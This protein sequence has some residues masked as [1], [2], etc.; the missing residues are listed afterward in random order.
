MR[1]LIGLLL[2]LNLGVFLAGMAMQY[3]SPAARAPLVF[4]AEKITL[5][6]APSV[7]SARMPAAE[8]A[9][10][11]EI[12]ADPQASRRLRRAQPRLQRIRAV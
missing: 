8:A 6:A 11:P 2:A 10:E 9:I 1:K 7:A 3:G 4:N 5:L 12:Q